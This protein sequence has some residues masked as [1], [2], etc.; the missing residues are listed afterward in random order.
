MIFGPLIEL[1]QN[2]ELTALNFFAVC[3]VQ[4]CQAHPISE[5]EYDMATDPVCKME[6]DEQSAAGQTNYDG[7]DYYF[8]SKDCE[9]KFEHD[10]QQ[11]LEA[12][13]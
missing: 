12:A 13:A 1:A 9:Q 10:P 5:G 8:C 7:K 11:F 3:N 2:A 6:V 4:H